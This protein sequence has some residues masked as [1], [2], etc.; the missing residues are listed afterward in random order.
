MANKNSHSE[1]LLDPEDKDLL[2]L[3]A[4][5]IDKS[6]GYVK[7]YRRGA[8]R[9]GS[10]RNVYLHHFIGKRLGLVGRIDHINRNRLDNRRCN[11]RIAT[12][13]EN[14][15]NKS[16]GRRNKTGYLG[17]SIH[18]SGKFLAT[19]VIRRKQHYVGLFNSAKEAAIARD[20]I[21]KQ[22]HGTFVS[23]NEIV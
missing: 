12:Q 22:L 23:L 16:L 7:A 11:I 4:W 8:G 21:A 6:N 17:V 3:H 18:F 10:N 14:N 19:V 9:R 15:R 13:A 1:I 2:L 20:R 5:T